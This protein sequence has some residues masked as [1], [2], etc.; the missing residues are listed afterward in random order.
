MSLTQVPGVEAVRAVGPVRGGAVRVRTLMGLFV[1]AD[2][3][4]MVRVGPVRDSNV[5][6][7]DALGGV[8]LEDAVCWRWDH[9][10]WLTLYLGQGRDAGPDN[11]RLGVV[12]ARLGMHERHVQRRLHGDGLVLG[13]TSDA[14]D[15][16]VPYEVLEQVRHGGIA[17]HPPAACTC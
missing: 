8:L 11:P 13:T 14:Q 12:L 5:A 6:I 7:S 2:P 10:S 4:R 16:D 9:G 15:V 17:V 3:A 1:P